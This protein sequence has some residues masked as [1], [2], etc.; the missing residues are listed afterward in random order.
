MKL[1]CV[2][3]FYLSGTFTV[4]IHFGDTVNRLPFLLFIKV[5]SSWYTGMKL[6][7]ARRTLTSK[8]KFIKK[9]K[10][11]HISKSPPNSTFDL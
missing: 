6:L 11:N 4:P 3:L 7:Q 1:M 9:T 5:S 10:N 8:N 2:L